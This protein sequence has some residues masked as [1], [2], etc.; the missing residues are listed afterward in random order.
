ME[1]VIYSMCDEQKYTKRFVASMIST[2]VL[3]CMHG[4][5]NEGG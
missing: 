4:A 5:G 3:G 1:M 2:H